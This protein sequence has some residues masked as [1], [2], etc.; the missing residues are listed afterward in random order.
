MKRTLI[1]LVITLVFSLYGCVPTP[2]K[3]GHYIGS[4]PDVSF[5]ITENGVENFSATPTK[6]LSCSHDP[7]PTVPIDPNNGAFTF[8]SPSMD[9]ING[10]VED[11]LA[12]GSFWLNDCIQS[13]G[14]GIVIG[15]ADGENWTA[16]WIAPKP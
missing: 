10:N 7:F 2:P 6:N 9:K 12:N 3:L 4:N 13:T 1:V 5:D 11:N 15:F 8:T 16:K 14:S